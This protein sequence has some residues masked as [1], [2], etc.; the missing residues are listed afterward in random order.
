MR[1]SIVAVALLALPL[2]AA[3]SSNSQQAAPA[4]SAP[5]AA[6]T[7]AP[8]TTVSGAPT[9]MSGAPTTTPGAGAG[10]PGSGLTAAQVSKALQD[11]GKLSAPTAD[12]IAT[13]YVQ[14]GLSDSGIQKII[15]SANGANPA[16]VSLGAADL[17][18]AGKATKRIATECVK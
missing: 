8:A 15:D 4:T 10:A 11:K 13:I 12:C 5:K 6:T 14:E 9:S 1:K 3:C 2:L 17:A 7:S 18:K 16:A